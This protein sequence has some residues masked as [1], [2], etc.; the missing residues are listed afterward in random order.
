MVD[1]GAAGRRRRVLRG[2]AAFLVLVPAGVVL[3]VAVLIY[4]ERCFDSCTGDTLATAAPDS[5]WRDV[6]QHFAYP[7]QLMLASVGSVGV[8]VLALGMLLT[9]KNLTAA[10]GMPALVFFALWFAL[11]ATG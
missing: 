6:R 4:G 11:L 7:L 10:G 1:I 8:L 2:F 3:L 9:R 5:G